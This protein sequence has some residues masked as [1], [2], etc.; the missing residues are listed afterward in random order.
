MCEPPGRASRVKGLGRLAALAGA[1]ALASGCGD[2]WGPETFPTASARGQVLLDGRP[3][4]GGW[5]EFAPIE[6]TVGRLRSAPVDR[7]GSFHVAGLPVGTV[8]IRLVGSPAAAGI[9]P[10]RVRSLKALSQV[11]A[12][13]RTIPP[14]GAVLRIDL[15]AEVAQLPS[16]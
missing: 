5:L 10:R 2:A 11:Y 13:R 7:R 9:D 3:I 1:L 15:A 4:G 6:G 8:G 12:I 16:S 14:G